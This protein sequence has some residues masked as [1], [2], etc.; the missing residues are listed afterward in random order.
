MPKLKPT[1]NQADIELLEKHFATKSDLKPFATKSDLKPFATKSDLKPLASKSDLNQLATKKDI[2]L[3]HERID[4]LEINIA[5]TI[6]L[7][8]ENHQKRLTRLENHLRLPSIP[9]N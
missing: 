3:L 6:A 4:L 8:L 9:I 5:K 7:P 1:L 2:K